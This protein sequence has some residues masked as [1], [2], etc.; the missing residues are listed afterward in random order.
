MASKSRDSKISNHARGYLR[1]G[2]GARRTTTTYQTR[3]VAGH[4]R[5]SPAKARARRRPGS[6]FVS[7]IPNATISVGRR[8]VPSGETKTRPASPFGRRGGSGGPVPTQGVPTG[9]S[10]RRG[11]DSVQKRPCGDDFPVRGG[12]PEGKPC[13][14]PS[15]CDFRGSALSPGGAHTNLDF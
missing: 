2:A 11:A 14:Y 13:V 10:S 1:G 5:N 7:R 6:D 3:K 9:R 15:R 4:V 12:R 8:S